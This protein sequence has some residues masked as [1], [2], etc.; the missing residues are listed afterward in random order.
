LRS[1]DTFFDFCR[2]EKIADVLKLSEEPDAPRLE[3]DD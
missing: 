1:F 2:Q 3:F